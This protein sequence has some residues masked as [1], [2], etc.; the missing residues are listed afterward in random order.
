M[1]RKD[2]PEDWRKYEDVEFQWVKN[3]KKGILGEVKIWNIH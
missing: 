1:F 3:T 2:C